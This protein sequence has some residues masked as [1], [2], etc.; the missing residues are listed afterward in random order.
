MVKKVKT[1]EELEIGDIVELYTWT[2]DSYVIEKYKFRVEDGNR[3]H[4][5]LSIVKLDK[6]NRTIYNWYG[7]ETR[8]HINNYTLKQ[9]HYG[10]FYLDPKE[11][12][13]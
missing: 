12:G 7:S 2:E 10:R 4:C 3:Y 8:Y 6:N 11:I 9:N 13:A 1:F 5:P